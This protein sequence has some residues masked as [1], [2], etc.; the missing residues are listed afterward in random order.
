MSIDA[1]IDAVTVIATEHCET[2]NDTGKDPAD[3]WDNCPSCHGATKANPKVRLHLSPRE[4]GGIAGQSVLTIVNPP[5]LDPEAL[6][7]MIGT[8]IWGGSGYLMVGDT[9]W[10]NRIGYTRIELVASVVTQ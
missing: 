3:N 7:G 4:K 9:K 5:T 10:A 1:R 6:A 8:E 2:C